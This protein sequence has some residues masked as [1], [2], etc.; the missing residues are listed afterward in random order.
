[1]N[2]PLTD[3]ERFECML[4]GDVLSQLSDRIIQ[5]YVGKL[6]RG[7]YRDLAAV[8]LVMKAVIKHPKFRT[9]MSQTDYMQ[10]LNTIRNFNDPGRHNQEEYHNWHW[11][12]YDIILSFAKKNHIV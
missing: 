7:V 10:T 4:S 12:V 2:Q 5:Q 8:S 6:N 11:V 3:E 1:M 9:L